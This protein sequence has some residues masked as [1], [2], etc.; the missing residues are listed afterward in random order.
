MAG[1]QV[2]AGENYTATVVAL[3]GDKAS[4]YVLPD[5][6]TK[7]FSIAKADYPD[8]IPNVELE[9]PVSADSYHVSVA[10]KMSSDAGTLTY[11]VG[12][13]SSEEFPITSGFDVEVDQNGLVTVTKR[14]GQ[15]FCAGKKL[16]VCINVDSTNYNQ[17]SITTVATFVN[18]T[19]AG[20][21]I[22]SGNSLS[23][24]YSE[25]L[26]TL[27]LTATVSHSGTNGTWTW[28]SNNPKV[29]T[30]VSGSGIHDS[31][32]VTIHG[33]GTTGITAKYDSDTTTGAATLILTVN[34]IFVPIPVAIT[35][36]SYNGTQLTGVSSDTAHYTLAGE[37]GQ[38][39]GDYVATATLKDTE[40]YRW[41][42][43]SIEVKYI[44]WSIEKEAGPAAPTG[45]KGITP[46][47]WANLDGQITGVNT[48]MEYSKDADF[49]NAFPCTGTTIIG[50]T[51]G[52]WYVRVKETELRKAGA[53]AA[54]VVPRV[55]SPVVR[56]NPGLVYNGSPQ[57]LVLADTVS[58]GKL[59]YAV[60]GRNDQKLDEGQF[61][62][63][64]P[65]KTNAGSY[66]VWYEIRGTGQPKPDEGHIYVD[67]AQKDLRNVF[68]YISMSPNGIY[69]LEGM[70]DIRDRV[71][72]DKPRLR[73][74]SADTWGC[75][76][77]PPTIDNPK[78]GA[79]TMRIHYFAAKDEELPT[80]SSG[81]YRYVSFTVSVDE[82][83]NYH[84]YNMTVKTTFYK[85]CSTNH[86]DTE[87]LYN[88]T[89]P[90]CTDTG[91]TGD[92]WCHD[93]HGIIPGDV[94]PVVPD[95][96]DFDFSNGV[97]TK[98]PTT[99]AWGEHTYYCRRNHNHTTTREDIPFL[100][101]ERNYDDF[102]ED[103]RFLSG[104]A[105]PK[106]EEKLLPGGGT[107]ETVTVAGEEVL[108]IVTDSEGKETVETRTWIGGLESSYTYTGSAIKPS[109]YAYDG[110][111]KLKEKKDYTV[112]RKNNRD[113]G[114]ASIT[115]EFKG[116]YKDNKPVTV[117]FEI[118]PAVLGVD[119]IAHEASL[120]R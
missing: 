75:I 112:S 82:M 2:N 29:A 79:T 90:N 92:T 81:T 106:T 40:K 31:C 120:R 108:K 45:L 118:K 52:T 51:D 65:T 23:V 70:I 9:V 111:T 107:Q 13:V 5:D 64:I 24:N 41:S 47:T 18:K 100:P 113:V 94:I 14:N 98:P 53:A 110:T 84:A 30:V 74:I 101:S 25:N 72:E 68:Y 77:Y 27:T 38:F 78:E 86:A 12:T 76:K 91:Y 11:S 36:L 59:Y 20:A 6:N 69:G 87:P 58:A 34:P 10:G 102:V 119:I 8:N 39:P 32:T 16:D 35:G 97:V 96:H 44:S 105:V 21:R 114:T 116:N 28:E 93:C 49:S 85:E 109:F 46:T 83:V 62:T 67:I 54:V 1:A 88:S 4:K 80:V 104:D 22:T 71:P 55:A 103:T 56:E 37:T 33:V 19:D 89:V 63:T 66:C 73:V 26:P 7:T 57:A 17:K 15:D 99:V 50:L 95:D 60:T 3:S 61:T 117:H 115:V 42:D 48:T 43:G